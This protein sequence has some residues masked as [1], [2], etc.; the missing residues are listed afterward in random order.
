MK[1]IKRLTWA[2]AAALG[3]AATSAGP[4]FAGVMFNHTEFLHTR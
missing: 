2:V 3:I 1:T 4:S